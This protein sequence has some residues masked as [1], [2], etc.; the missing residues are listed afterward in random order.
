MQA[1]TFGRVQSCHL[2]KHFRRVAVRNA[3]FQHIVNAALRYQF[4][5]M[6]VVRCHAAA[7]AVQRCN[8]LQQFQQVV[9]AACLT[10][11]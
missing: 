1:E 2:Q 7:A 10:Q 4:I 3:N 6:A 9:R 11:H 8:A 5:Q